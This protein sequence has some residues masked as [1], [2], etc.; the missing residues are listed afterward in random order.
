MHPTDLSA[1]PS[2]K[3]GADLNPDPIRQAQGRRTPPQQ[4]RYVGRALQAPA[5]TALAPSTCYLRPH[6]GHMRFS[7]LAR[8]VCA[9]W[10]SGFLPMSP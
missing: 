3:A 9:D 8:Q 2:A 7:E 10:P 6:G 1:E 5:G 4:S